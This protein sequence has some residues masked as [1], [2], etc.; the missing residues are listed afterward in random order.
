VK[1]AAAY[2]DRKGIESPRLNAELLLSHILGCSRLDLYLRFDE[3]LDDKERTRYRNDLQQRARR[4]PLQFI[5]GKIEFYSL[6][7][8]V[9]E[10]IFIPRPETELLVERVE[11]LIGCDRPVRF[12]EM[13][14]GT[15][16][17]SATLAARH[18]TWRGAAFDISP[19]AARLARENAVALGVSD[20][21]GICVA[22]GFEAF[23]RHVTF[24][25]LVANP[26][27]VAAEDID[28]LPEEVSRYESR[29]ALDG[30]PDGMRFYPV[31]ARAGEKLL[32]RGGLLAVEIGVGQACRVGELLGDAGYERIEM[33][34]DYNGIERVMTAFRPHAG[35]GGDD[36]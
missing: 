20:R 12:I 8:G 9:R 17:I 1:L 27:Y 22:D 35:G 26:P 36:G 30:G 11:D 10:G 6:P 16:V 23:A 18:P 24:D 19:D 14:V 33:R 3:R 4:Y 32:R 21:L 25:L 2:L 15:A 29:T 5:T 7:F 28:G 13:G 31:L 34:R